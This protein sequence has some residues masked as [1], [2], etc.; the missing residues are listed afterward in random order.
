MPVVDLSPR[1]SVGYPA[2]HHLAHPPFLPPFPSLS[3]LSLSL[4][5]TLYLSLSIPPYFV[6]LLYLS[7]ALSLSYIYN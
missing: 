4:T 6:P 7:L 1:L 2:Q 5:L 3:S